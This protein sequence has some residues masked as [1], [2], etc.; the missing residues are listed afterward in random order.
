MC[1]PTSAQRECF[2][3]HLSIPLLSTAAT[4]AIRVNRASARYY[5]RSRL[6]WGAVLQLAHAR[7][8]E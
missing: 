7:Y 4:I 5:R 8:V 3:T 1:E 2:S 6:P